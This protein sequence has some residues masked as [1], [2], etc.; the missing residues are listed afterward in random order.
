M[1]KVERCLDRCLEV[2]KIDAL[3]DLSIDATYDSNMRV[4]DS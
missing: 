3:R 2:I 4:K 1:E